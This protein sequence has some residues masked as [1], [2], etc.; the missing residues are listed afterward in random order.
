MIKKELISILMLV[1]MLGFGVVLGSGVTEIIYQNSYNQQVEDYFATVYNVTY[2]PNASEQISSILSVTNNISDPHKKLL[3][4]A[5][6]EIAG[7]YNLWEAANNNS[8]NYNT[9]RIGAYVYD[10]A[11]RIRA[12]PGAQFIKDPYWITYQRYGACGELAY[13]FAYVANK[14]G[15]ETKVVSAQYVG[16]GNHAW[17]EVNMSSGLMYYDPTWYYDYRSYEDN[18]SIIWFGP[19]TNQTVWDIQLI[20]ILDNDGNDVINRY[21]SVNNTPLSYS[22]PQETMTILLIKSQLFEGENNYVLSLI[23]CKS[24]DSIYWVK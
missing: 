3:A 9:S 24:N 2:F 20:N 10:D 7:F 18:D 17:V 6:W 14:S 1:I 15:F 19:L 8:L 21:P 16:G 11:G 22:I 4:I 5:D 23:E 13:L 12:N